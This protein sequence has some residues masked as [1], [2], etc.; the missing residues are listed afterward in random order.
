MVEIKRK[1]I[2]FLLYLIVLILYSGVVR[3]DIIYDEADG[4]MTINFYEPLG[5]TFTADIDYLSPT[6]GLYFYDVNN[7]ETGLL[8]MSLYEGK[9]FDGSLL[10][11]NTFSFSPGCI[12]Y[13]DVA[14][15]GISLSAG[16]IY[17]IGIEATTV[18]WAIAIT[19]YCSRRYR[20]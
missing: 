14:F 12:G 16:R 18:R 4:W 11:S 7:V 13:Y 19:D 5:Q 6:I 10:S 20:L 17:T 8:T 15:S 2:V 3:A 9:G 1:M